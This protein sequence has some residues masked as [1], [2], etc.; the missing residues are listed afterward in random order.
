[1]SRSTKEKENPQIPIMQPAVHETFQTNYPACLMAFP[2]LMLKSNDEQREAIIT[3][4][5]SLIVFPVIQLDILND[6]L[7]L[8]FLLP[9]HNE[10]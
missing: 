10:R 7:L 8:S 9:F 6:G 3:L 2:D 1:M 5:W 4:C